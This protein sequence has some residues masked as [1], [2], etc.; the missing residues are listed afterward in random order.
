MCKE[1]ISCLKVINYTKKTYEQQL[2]MKIK[3]KKWKYFCLEI[4][5][6]ANVRSKRSK[7]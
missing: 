2:K 5:S 3:E 7:Q 4:L 1:I 6:N